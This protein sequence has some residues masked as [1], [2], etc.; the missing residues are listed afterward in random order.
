MVDASKKEVI[1][2]AFKDANDFLKDPNSPPYD[3]SNT[4]KLLFYGLFKQAT[5][6]E[7]KGKKLLMITVQ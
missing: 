6:G 7:C 2:Q 3:S 4:D 1:E 5:V